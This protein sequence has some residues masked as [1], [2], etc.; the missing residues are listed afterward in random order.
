MCSKITELDYDQNKF[1]IHSKVGK[2][3][4]ES[5]SQF[6]RP[7]KCNV[8]E[9][10][11]DKNPKEEFAEENKKKTNLYQERVGD[12]RSGEEDDPIKVE[13]QKYLE[14]MNEKNKRQMYRQKLKETMGDDKYRE[15]KMQIEKALQRGKVD[16]NGNL[17]IRKKLTKEEIR[18][19]G[20][21]RQQKRREG[22]KEKYGEEEYRKMHSQQIAQVRKNKKKLVI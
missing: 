10:M 1:K 19:K 4:I 20:R 21:L 9:K 17:L 16:E 12:N 8:K 5:N 7:E 14:E 6:A 3:L 11:K 15:K 13:S 18:E 22:L 2:N